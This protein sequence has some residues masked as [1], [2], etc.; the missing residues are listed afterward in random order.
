V[1]AIV[2]AYPLL[3]GASHEDEAE[4]YR[5]LAESTDVSG[6]ELPWTGSIAGH[7]PA[8]LAEHLPATFTSIVTSIPATMAA[9]GVDARFGLASRD[10][11]GRRAALAQVRSM[12]EAVDALHQAAGR[13]VVDGMEVHSA[14]RG[15]EA[16]ASRT[17]FRESLDEIAGWQRTG[18]RLLVEHVDAHT[19]DPA[20]AKGFLG[21]DAELEAVRNIQGAGLVLNWARSA[22]EL[23]DPDRVDEHIVRA[24][25]CGV[26]AGLIF[27]GVAADWVDGHL[28]FFPDDAESLLTAARAESALAAAGDGAFIGVKLRPNAQSVTV[29]E[30]ADLVLG[31]L[32]GLRGN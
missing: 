13:R 23:R 4:L 31:S 10:P 11:D 7:D 18:V 1:G 30:R 8:W 21:L 29:R 22:I 5:L 3:S 12:V 17:A 9:I 28:P 32:R 25:E 2:G 14:P 6:L 20:P 24:R 16:A 26:L 27:S 15:G 19:D